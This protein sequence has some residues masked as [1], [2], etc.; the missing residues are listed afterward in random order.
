MKKNSEDEIQKLTD[1]FSKQMEESFKLKEV[2][3]MK[4]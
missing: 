1:T 2:E 3:I 4:V